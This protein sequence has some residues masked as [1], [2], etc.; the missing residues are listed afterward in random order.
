MTTTLSSTT[1]SR[2]P[3]RLRASAPLNALLALSS[4]GMIAAGLVF[5]VVSPSILLSRHCVSSTS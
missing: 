2:Q 5:G 3:K 4:D 1:D